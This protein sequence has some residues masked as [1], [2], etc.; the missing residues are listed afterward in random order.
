MTVSA[1]YRA[2]VVELFEPFGEVS[3]RAMFGGGGVY[4]QGVMIGLIA[5]EQVY[6][7]VDEHNLPDFEAAGQPA[8][9]FERAGGKQGTMSYRLIPDMLYDEPDAL[10]SWADGAFQA[11]RRASAKRKPKKRRA[12]KA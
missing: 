9:T 8:F 5:D 3:V 7:K 4:H 12:T 6:L 1:E 2:F 11:A 10:V